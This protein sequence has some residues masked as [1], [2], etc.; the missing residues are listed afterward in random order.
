ML[1]LCKQQSEIAGGDSY[2]RRFLTISTFFLVSFLSGF[3]GALMDGRRESVV[4]MVLVR[5]GLY[6]FANV[7]FA[8]STT[9]TFSS[10][11]LIFFLK[12]NI[13]LG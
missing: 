9:V 2:E 10:F 3:L 12:K 8:S 13:Y 5:S 4:C 1:R 7:I 11:I 6:T